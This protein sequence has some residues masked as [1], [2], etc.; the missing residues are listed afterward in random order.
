M[1][2]NSAI[3][4]LFFKMTETFKPQGTRTLTKRPTSDGNNEGASIIQM[5][6]EI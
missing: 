5:N 4:L 2:A 6:I 1:I 3:R